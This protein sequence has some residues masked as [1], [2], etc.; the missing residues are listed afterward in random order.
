MGFVNWKTNK[1]TNFIKIVPDDST[2]TVFSKLINIF[3]LKA[4]VTIL[5]GESWYV[6][7]ALYLQLLSNWINLIKFLDKNC[8]GYLGKKKKK[9]RDIKICLWILSKVLKTV[10]GFGQQGLRLESEINILCMYSS[11]YWGKHWA[12]ISFSIISC[13]NIRRC[14]LTFSSNLYYF[15]QTENT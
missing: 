6:S 3:S 1:Q 4:K 11:K 12:Y 15:I 5:L 7:Q 9:K 2:F 10:W 8:L 14:V 13:L